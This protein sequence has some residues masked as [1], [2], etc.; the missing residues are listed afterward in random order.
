MEMIDIWIINL[1][2]WY[3]S[4]GKLTDAVMS[5]EIMQIYQGL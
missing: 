2:F 4:G 1:S 3:S 5:Y